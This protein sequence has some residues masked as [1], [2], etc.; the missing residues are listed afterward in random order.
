MHWLKVRVFEQFFIK[1]KSVFLIVFSVLFLANV[2]YAAGTSLLPKTTDTKVISGGESELLQISSSTSEGVS[3]NKFSQ[4][5]LSSYD[6]VKVINNASLNNSLRN[7]AEADIIT[8]EVDASISLNGTIELAGKPAELVLITSGS[9]IVCNNCEFKNFT[10][11]SLVTGNVKRSTDNLK[12]KS[13][14]VNANTITINGTGGLYAPA[15]AF[16][17]IHSGRLNAYAS[18]STNLKA[19]KNSNNEISPDINGTLMIASGNTRISLGEYEYEYVNGEIT[20]INANAYAEFYGAKGSIASGSVNINVLDDS[21]LTINQD[22]NTQ[23]DLTMAS[24]YRGKNIVPDES[25]SLKTYGDISLNSNLTSGGLVTFEAGNNIEFSTY[26]SEASYILKANKLSVAAGMKFKN[27]ISLDTKYSEFSANGIINEGLISSEVESYMHS[28]T[29][30]DNQFG[31]LINAGDLFIQADSIFNNGTERPHRLVPKP[32]LLM[33]KGSS[34]ESGTGSNLEPIPDNLEAKTV[35][36]LSAYIQANNIEIQAATFNNINPFFVMKSPNEATPTTYD[37]DEDVVSAIDQVM[38]HAENNLTI[39]ASNS[40]KNSSGVLE[41]YSGKL[42][43]FTP[44]LNNERYRIRVEKRPGS[45]LPDNFCVD[46]DV[47]RLNANQSIDTNVLGS[48]V[49]YFSPAGRIYSGSSAILAPSITPTNKEEASSFKNE[50]SFIEVFGDF[51]VTVN[52]VEQIGLLLE[53]QISVNVATKHS[54]RVCSRKKW[55]ICYRR[56][57]KRWVTNEPSFYLVETGMLPALF[58]VEGDLRGSGGGEFKL[59]TTKI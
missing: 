58:S 12:I 11:V 39:I 42:A 16:L 45:G 57:T 52:S 24:M 56:K 59:V 44:H 8:I 27:H 41:T 1:T 26:S 2:S 54:K 30:I 21:S 10:R 22:I 28:T 14:Q 33:A 20:S 15:V 35:D 23:G 18:I 34:F 43:M 49:S 6:L 50:M 37:S 51:N 48:Y 9:E 36:S 13:L 53:A 32:S 29:S 7:G 3:F 38:V 5:N 17:D 47:C 31:G 46:H 19:S 4:F 40:I 25:V 55:G